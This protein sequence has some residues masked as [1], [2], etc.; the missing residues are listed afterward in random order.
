[1]YGVALLLR[2]KDLET[3]SY[4]KPLLKGNHNGILLK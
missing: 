2:D 4:H 1:M 3:G